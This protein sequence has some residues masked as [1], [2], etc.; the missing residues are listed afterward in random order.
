MKK[1]ETQ[2]PREFGLIRNKE[3]K[4]KRL[5]MGNVVLYSATHVL[6]LLCGMRKKKKKD[7]G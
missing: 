1:K 7:R 5:G 6:D 4:M 2:G 3:E